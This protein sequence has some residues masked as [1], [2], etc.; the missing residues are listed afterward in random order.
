MHAIHRELVDRCLRRQVGSVEVVDAA[1]RFVGSEQG[2]LDFVVV[3]HGL[4]ADQDSLGPMGAASKPIF[5][6]GF[7]HQDRKDREGRN[8][9]LEFFLYVDEFQSFTPD[10]FGSILSEAGKDHL[11]FTLSHQSTDQ[12]RPEV[13]DAVFGNVGLI[14]AF[15]LDAM[16][17]SCFNKPLESF[18]R[19]ANSPLSTTAKSMS[20]FL[21]T[22]I[23]LAFALNAHGTET[24]RVIDADLKQIKGPTLDGL[25]GLRRGGPRRR[26]FARR[27]AQAARGMPPRNRF[28]IHPDARAVAG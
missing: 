22:G 7:L 28:Q 12:L 24:N 5:R 13:R 19:P 15:A 4:C 10:S 17:P 6:N 9:H 27:L 1:V 11:C 21:S 16:T 18:M 20:V 14:I 3:G 8:F 26:R 25:A 2:A 23:L